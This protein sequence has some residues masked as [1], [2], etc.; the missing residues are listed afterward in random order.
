MIVVDGRWTGRHGIARFAG[1]VVARLPWAAEV[2]A[3]VPPTSPRDVL[4][5]WRLRL[6]RQD[7]VY[8]PGFNAGL[9]RARQILTLHDLIHLD[10]PAERSKAKEAYYEAV[11]R[12]AVRRAGIV[13][14]VSETSK[15]RI[16]TWL[17]PS[18]RVE[19]V[20]VGNGCAPAFLGGSTP[21][22]GRGRFL[23]VGNLKPHKNVEVLFRSL[24]LRTA[25]RLTLVTADVHRAEALAQR[26]GVVDR[27]EV[28]S[29]LTD[30]ELAEVYRRHDAVLMPSLL[31]GFGLP[32]L[33]AVASGRRVGYSS[34]CASVAEIVGGEGVAVGSAGDAEEWAQAMDRLLEA[35]PSSVAADPAWRDRYDWGSVSRRV[36]RAVTSV[37]A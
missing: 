1:E 5:T 9:T 24:A 37:T 2:R 30:A 7:V 8:S 32:A 20:E 17:G 13:L 22:P 6:G 3:D 33:E 14:T 11:V 31:E 16:E 18:S 21:P 29:G 34:G 27:V 26:H 28:R 23:Y 36:E 4:S 35:G 15:A 25:N 10:E 12:P 19:V